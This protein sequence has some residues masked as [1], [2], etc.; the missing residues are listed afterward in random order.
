MD[1]SIHTLLDFNSKVESKK[2]ESS[3]IFG[4]IDNSP[5]DCIKK[6]VTKKNIIHR[7]LERQRRQ[8]MAKLYQSLRSHMPLE[9]L[10]G[11]RSIS[12]QIHE[13]ERY[14]KDLQ[15]RIAELNE[16]RD[17]IKRLNNISLHTLNNVTSHKNNSTSSLQRDSVTVE[18]CRVGIAVINVNTNVRRGLQVSRVLQVLLGEGLSIVSCISVKVNG[19]L[20]HT[21]ESKVNEGT[22][23]DQTELQ[24]KLTDSIIF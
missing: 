13:A 22:S 20:L 12:D 8:E 9:Y 19:R 14:I 7:D 6:I 16:K 2:R 17:E 5:N 21:I 4:G 15:K 1:S 24:Q 18:I 10:K 3:M 23:I 11:K